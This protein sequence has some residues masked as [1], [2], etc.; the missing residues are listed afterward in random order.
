MRVY[1]NIEANYKLLIGNNLEFWM[2]TKV[3]AIRPYRKKI[4]GC[5]SAAISAVKTPVVIN[6]LSNRS[7]NA[8][9]KYFNYY[10]NSN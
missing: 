4:S 10:Q 9:C 3:F 1:L 2:S 7:L 6:I 8:N 5:N